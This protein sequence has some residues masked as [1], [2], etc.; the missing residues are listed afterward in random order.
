[1]ITFI[2]KQKTIEFTT[3]LVATWGISVN[4]SLTDNP[5]KQVIREINNPN[6]PAFVADIKISPT[7]RL[8]SA[9][10]IHKVK[11]KEDRF[12]IKKPP[13]KGR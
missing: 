10:C 13:T 2:K 6:M 3:P 7:C 1:M 8:E 4:V 9:C 5:A 12:K 11:E